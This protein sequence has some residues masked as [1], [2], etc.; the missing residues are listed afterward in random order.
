MKR[1]RAWAGVW[2]LILLGIWIWMDSTAGALPFVICLFLLLADAACAR[3]TRGKLRGRLECGKAAQKGEEIVGKL[4][5]ENC[6]RFPLP[7]VSGCLAYENLL[8]GEKG[9]MRFRT[10]LGARGKETLTWNLKSRYC[11]K[12]RIALESINSGG[13]LN[14]FDL[15]ETRR[16]ECFC[17]VLPNLFPIEVT[18]TE[19]FVLNQ[20][21]VRYS[22][23]RRGEDPAEIYG[24]REYLPG[25]SLK[26]IH[27][28]LT[29][30]MG[31]WYIKELGMPIENSILLLYESPSDQ[32]SP[33]VTDARMEA[34][35]SLSQAL[36]SKDYAHQIGWYSK[37]D[38]G[39][40]F[41][42]VNSEDELA[43]LTGG[44]LELGIAGEKVSALECYLEAWSRH[45]FSHVVYLTSQVNG[46][47]IGTLRLQ[48]TV[49]VLQCA[50]TEEGLDRSAG[51]CFLPEKKEEELCQ[52]FI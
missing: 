21:S 12:M 8:T 20:E 48:C 14:L 17:M 41:C 40:R 10:G 13:L 1:Q 38:K 42:Q 22:G 49:Q 28:K 23:T 50:E 25:D 37:K 35:L 18:L 15:R 19:G 9:R 4:Q 31:E 36:L 7:F 32:D 5:L 52:I 29:G 33:E 51:I 43:E 26:H 30:K 3:G 45:P 6:G 27:W 2:L 46:E 44:I 24:L 39:L 11:G 34:L 16:E 47:T